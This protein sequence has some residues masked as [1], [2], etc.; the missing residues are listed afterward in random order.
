MTVRGFTACVLYLESKY[1]YPSLLFGDPESQAAM[2]MVLDDMN[3][4]N[5]DNTTPLADLIEQAREAQPFILGSQMSL[6]DIAA[7]PYRQIMPDP[8]RNTLTSILGGLPR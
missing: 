7:A 4:T 1:P 6:I 2:L 8:Y 3:Q 5:V